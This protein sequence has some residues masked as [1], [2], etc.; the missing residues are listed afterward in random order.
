MY[1][2]KYVM[3]RLGLMI[4]TFAIIMIMCFCLIKL[5]PIIVTQGGPNSDPLI[6][7]KQLEAR[8]Y[9]QNVAKGAN[10]II[11]YERVP[12]LSQLWSYLTSIFTK[13][14]FGIATTYG[15]YLNQPVWNVFIKKLPPT[16]LINLYSTILGVPIGLGLGIFAAL[17][18][19]KWQDQVINVVIILLISVPS[20]IMGLLIQYF[21]CFKWGWFPITMKGVRLFYS[22]D[23]S[24]YDSRGICVKFRIDSGLRPFYARRIV[25]SFN[26]RIYVACAYERSYERAGNFQTR[27]A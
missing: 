13:G 22:R 15:E 1:M 7:Y 26:E 27:N 14:D 24:F 18:K 23:V 25:G 12:I 10:G 17:K 6:P 19:N 5:L 21:M 9:I 4:L 16:I 8:G 11:T 2:F 20:I 3:K